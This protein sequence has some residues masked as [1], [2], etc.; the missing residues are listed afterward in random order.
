MS[1]E[2]SKGEK[3][4]KLAEAVLPIQVAEETLVFDPTSNTPF[5]D[6]FKTLLYDHTRL[7]IPL[8]NKAFHENYAGDERIEFRPHEHLI[9]KPGGKQEKRI[10]DC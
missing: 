2:K 10:L 4:A 8:I 5:D 7:V 1:T 6:V 9:N 3:A